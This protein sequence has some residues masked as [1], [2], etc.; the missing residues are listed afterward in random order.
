MAE[1]SRLGLKMGGKIETFSGLSGFGDLFVTCN[2]KHSRNW[3][4]GNLMGQGYSMQEAMTKV[5]QV[6]E[7]INSAQAAL[8][9]AQKYEVEMPIV[10]QINLVLFENKSPKDALTDLL[11]RDR[12]REYKSLEW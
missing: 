12:R 7:G 10:E 3:N 4:A 5:N 6:V 1:I 11:M 2:S 8:A 9:L